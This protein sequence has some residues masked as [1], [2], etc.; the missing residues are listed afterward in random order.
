MLA[1]ETAQSPSA[2]ILWPPERDVQKMP[3]RG[4][5]PCLQRLAAGQVASGQTSRQVSG[6]TSGQTTGAMEAVRL[7][8]SHI[9]QFDR[10]DWVVYVLWVGMMFG[11]CGVQSAFLAVGH[12]AGAFF[13]PAAYFLPIG[14]FIFSCAIAV[15][16]IGHRTVYK[17][18][19]AKGEAFVHHIIMFAGV[20]SCVLLVAAYPQ[21]EFLPSLRWF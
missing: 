7:Y 5:R 20:G 11:L 12:Q 1:Q 2:L 15:D 13:P 21:N 14:A 9:T 17:D 8:F 18:E 10:E 4:T 6:Q 16:T 19:L 3:P